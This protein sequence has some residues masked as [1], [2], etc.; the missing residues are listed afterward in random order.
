MSRPWLLASYVETAVSDVQVYLCTSFL[1]HIWNGIIVS[2]STLSVYLLYSLK[3]GV[4]HVSELWDQISFIR[5]DFVFLI[6]VLLMLLVFLIFENEFR[7]VL[8]FE[9]IKPDKFF[10][11]FDHFRVLH[12]VENS[13][14]VRWWFWRDNS[15]IL[16]GL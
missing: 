13:E 12:W 3:W 5:Y 4:I 10:S 16:F 8:E 9:S 7:D 1:K 11:F 15:I 2:S 14:N 6:I